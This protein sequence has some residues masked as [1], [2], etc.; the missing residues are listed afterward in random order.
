MCWAVAAAYRKDA[1][2]YWGDAVACWAAGAGAV[3]L[4][5][6]WAAEAARATLVVGAAEAAPATLVV[7][8]AEENRSRRHRIPQAS[9]EAWTPN[10]GI[11]QRRSN[12]ASLRLRS[13]G[14][15]GTPR[16]T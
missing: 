1:A 6:Y 16:F 9:N 3:S 5:A 4:V 10:L 2:V 7:V 14:G 12:S 13:L 11:C 15:D 8:A